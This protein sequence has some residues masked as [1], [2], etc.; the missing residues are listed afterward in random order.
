MGTYAKIYNDTLG[1][2]GIFKGHL[3]TLCGRINVIP[4]TVNE[5]RTKEE[6]EFIKVVKYNTPFPV[7]LG[8][9]W[10][11]KDQIARR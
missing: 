3:V 7:L 6:F 2:I 4:I 1:N 10:I 5:V 11:I 9:K 8:N